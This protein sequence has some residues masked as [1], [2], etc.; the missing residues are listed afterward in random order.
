MTDSTTPTMYARK[1]HNGFYTLRQSQ[2]TKRYFFNSEDAL[3][4]AAK[5][6]PRVSALG[7]YGRALVRTDISSQE[8]G[9]LGREVVRL[10]A[11][12]RAIARA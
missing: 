3:L 1:E 8:V 2:F 11:E 10:R 5:I 9:F 12:I 7:H 4:F 6:N